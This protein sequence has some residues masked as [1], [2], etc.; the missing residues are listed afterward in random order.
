MTESNYMKYRG[1]CKEMAEQAAAEDPSLTVVRG[2]YYCPLWNRREPHWWC[3]KPDGEIVDPTALQFPSGGLGIGEYEP[4]YGY[5]ACEECG[6][7]IHED[8]RHAGYSVCSY[9]CYGSMVGLLRRSL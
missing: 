8:E 5:L 4:F 2:H 6:K 3:V 1:K 7:T 9:E